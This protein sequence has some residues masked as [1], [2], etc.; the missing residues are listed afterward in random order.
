V[1]RFALS[2]PARCLV[3]GL[4]V[5]AV[6]PQCRELTTVKK[7]QEGGSLG[8]TVA[9]AARSLCAVSTTLSLAGSRGNCSKGTPL[10]QQSGGQRDGMRDAVLKVE[11]IQV[12][13]S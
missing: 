5:K 2:I 8:L 12:T 9:R 3:S 4:A 7:Q 13:Y 11:T 1:D 10:K 6:T